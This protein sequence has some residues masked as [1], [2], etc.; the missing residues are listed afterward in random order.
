MIIEASSHVRESRIEITAM[1]LSPDI[2]DSS[3]VMQGLYQPHTDRATV[4]GTG[5]RQPSSCGKGPKAVGE[6]V[7][8][9]PGIPSKGC[10]QRLTSKGSDRQCSVQSR[11]SS[12]R[13]GKPSTWQR[14]ADQGT[15]EIQRT[16][17]RQQWL[18]VIRSLMTNVVVESH[19]KEVFAR[20]ALIGKP[21][22]SKGAGPVWE[23][24]R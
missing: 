11:R 13:T 5:T 4:T 15:V 8:V 1:F 6:S 9:L 23:G 7:M 20:T 14:A 22:A 3:D 12:L 17:M 24:A 2:M 10:L 18:K 19:R 21:D 16:W